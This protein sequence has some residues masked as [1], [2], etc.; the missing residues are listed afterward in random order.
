MTIRWSA[1]RLA[2]LA[3]CVTGALSLSGRGSPLLDGGRIQLVEAQPAPASIDTRRGVP[4]T[5]TEREAIR[6]EMRTMVRSLNLVLHGLGDGNAAM[7]EQ[8]ARTSGKVLAL[9]PQLEA[10]LPPQFVQLDHRTHLRFD[11]LAEASKGGSIRGNVVAALAAIT[12]YCVT[13][14]DVF[15][16][17]EVP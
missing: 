4:L 9:D 15:R 5:S 14:H 10:K 2:T 17:E 16:V 11:R 12:G 1:Q 7:V 6:R 13:C 3:L 8:A